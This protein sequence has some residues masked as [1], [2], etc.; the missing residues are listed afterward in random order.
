MCAIFEELVLRSFNS[1]ACDIQFSSTPQTKPANRL[2]AGIKA[3]QDEFLK[4][5]THILLK[6]FF[7]DTLYK[8]IFA[9]YVNSILREPLWCMIE[10]VWNIISDTWKEVRRLLYYECAKTPPTLGGLQSTSCQDQ[11][12]RESGF[13]ELCTVLSCTVGP[14]CT[15]LGPDCTVL[16]NWS[17]EPDRCTPCPSLQSAAHMYVCTSLDF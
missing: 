15:V 14:D 12:W 5:S 11:I 4:D 10:P 2:M 7:W 6:T 1:P 17:L 3:P 13:A 8:K 16:Q 9:M